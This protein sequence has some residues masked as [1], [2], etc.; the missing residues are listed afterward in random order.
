[1]LFPTV[2]HGPFSSWNSWFQLY[3]NYEAKQSLGASPLI[4]LSCPVCGSVVVFPAHQ[5]GGEHACPNCR[6]GIFVPLAS[7]AEGELLELL[8]RLRQQGWQ[9]LPIP[10]SEETRDRMRCETDAGKCGSMQ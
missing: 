3:L 8:R 9:S 1:M 4:A 6:Q 2:C 10:L 5:A 7:T